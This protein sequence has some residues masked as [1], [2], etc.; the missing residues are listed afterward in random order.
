[1]PLSR[2]IA[3]GS[4]ADRSCDRTTHAR[5]V[6][7]AVSEWDA[8]RVGFFFPLVLVSLLSFAPPASAQV[9]ALPLT[10]RF[11]ATTS[12]KVFL[13]PTSPSSTLRNEYQ[14]ARGLYG[15]AIE[16]QIPFTSE[17]SI[18]LAVEYLRHLEEGDRPVSLGGT[19]RTLPVRDGFVIIPLEVGVVVSIP[20]SDETFRL[21]MGGGI[22]MTVIQRI[23]QIADVGVT[24]DGMPAA[25]GIHVAVG[26]DVRVVDGL[27]AHLSTRFRDPEQTVTTRYERVTTVYNGTTLVFPSTPMDTRINMDGMS[28]SAGLT[29]DLQRLL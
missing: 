16:L 2:T 22:G 6:S 8:R 7:F 19:L 14:T 25:Y 21:T 1:M 29:V 27:F 23:Q 5:V 12:A 24:S 15:A 18:S 13:N 4:T 20:I 17:F 11:A 28:L 10:A 3:T 26:F 9:I